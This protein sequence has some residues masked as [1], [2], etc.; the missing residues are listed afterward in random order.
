[1]LAHDAEPCQLCSDEHAASSALQRERTRRLAKFKQ[2][3]HDTRLD[4]AGD[5]SLSEFRS[6]PGDYYY[7]LDSW[8]A[9]WRAFL[10]SRSDDVVPSALDAST[11][12]CAEHG[13]AF[14]APDEQSPPVGVV[15]P[16]FHVVPALA[17][18]RLASFYGAPGI[19][20]AH[21]LA[22]DDDVEATQAIDAARRIAV[23]SVVC[24]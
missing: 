13:R 11:L 18:H 1:M 23:S 3:Q 10:A 22:L 12:L 20:P 21:A 17:Y 9:R 19:E 7:V 5:P 14:Y 24:Y 2:Q 16:R 4:A 8:L 6:L 15:R